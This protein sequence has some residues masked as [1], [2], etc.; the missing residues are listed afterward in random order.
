MGVCIEGEACREVPQH[1]AYRLDIHT[2]LEGDSC[3][4]VAEVV[5]SDFRDAS[6]FEDTLE[7]IVDAIWGDGS[8]VGGRE[9]ILVVGLDFLR[10][11]NFYRL[12]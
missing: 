7:H 10:F 3:E 2:I 4:G 12:L 1:T 5:E 6:P 8:A 9:Y 11:E